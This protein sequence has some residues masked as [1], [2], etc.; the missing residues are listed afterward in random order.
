MEKQSCSDYSGDEEESELNMAAVHY[1]CI[2]TGIVQG[3]GSVGGWN[4]LPDRVGVRAARLQQIR[5]F[6]ER[7]SFSGTEGE[8]ETT[9]KKIGF[10]A[11]TSVSIPVKCGAA[12]DALITFLSELLSSS[13]TFKP[14]SR[15][16]PPAVPNTLVLW[17]RLPTMP[18]N[19]PKM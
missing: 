4:I 5:L 19:K 14:F 12:S 9:R 2:Q 8:D 17:L 3:L 7:V 13:S 18:C 11:E 16:D 1:G 6:K 10:N 15:P